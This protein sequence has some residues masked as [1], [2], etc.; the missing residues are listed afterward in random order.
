M[1]SSGQRRRPSAHH[2]P[3]HGPWPWLARVVHGGALRCWC[4]WSPSSS[5]ASMA[6]STGRHLT[7]ENFR[8]AIDPLYAGD[9]PRSARIAGAATLIALMIGYPA[10]YAITLQPRAAADGA[11]VPR[12]AAVL[13]QL[14][15]PHLC[16]DRASQPRRADQPGAAS[17]RLAA[18]P[19]PIL[20]NEFAVILGLVY[21]YVPF[22]ILAVYSRRCSGST[23]RWP[24]PRAISAP[25]RGRRSCGSRCP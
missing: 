7:L 4:W 16:L 5:A 14:S 1:R 6:A 2:E 10:A 11:P 12:H 9:L 8:R 21:N 20:Y 3:A 17:A 23:H 22:V 15:D 18:E 13:D 19:L 25:G 24:R